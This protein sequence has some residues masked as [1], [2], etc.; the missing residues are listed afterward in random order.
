MDFVEKSN[1]V[2]AKCTECDKEFT[3]TKLG[4]GEAPEGF[5]LSGTCD[6]D[7]LPQ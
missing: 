4:H 7:D 6:A 2:V 3:V 5:S 1:D